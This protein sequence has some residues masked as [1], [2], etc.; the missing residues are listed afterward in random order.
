[1]AIEAQGQW[2][3][4]QPIL[5]PKI[6]LREGPDKES[7]DRPRLGELSLGFAA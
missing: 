3:S 2:F 7:Q 4:E 5:S 1:M 6:E